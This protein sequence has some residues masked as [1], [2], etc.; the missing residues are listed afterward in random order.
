MS[1]LEELSSRS[2]ELRHG[3]SFPAMP[4]QRGLIIDDLGVTR[5]MPTS[6]GDQQQDN[7]DKKDDPTHTH[8]C[9]GH[10]P[11]DGLVQ[12]W[13]RDTVAGYVVC[14]EG[15]GNFRHWNTCGLWGEKGDVHSGEM[16]SRC[17]EPSAGYTVKRSA[18]CSSSG[19]RKTHSRLHEPHTERPWRDVCDNTPSGVQALCIGRAAYSKVYGW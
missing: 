13:G 11:Q 4:D 8:Q 15:P 18:I 16:R 2:P 6:E 1:L 3:S 12:S 17:R 14:G 10:N 5:C 7:E 19:H 9:I